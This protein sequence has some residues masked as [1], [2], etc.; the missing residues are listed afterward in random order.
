MNKVFVVIISI[1]IGGCQPSQ[2][3][4]E[5]IE[6]YGRFSDLEQLFRQYENQTLVINFWATSCGPCI[7]EMPH[8]NEL[9]AEQNDN[10]KIVLVSLDEPKYLD[11]RVYPFVK[12]HQLKPEAVLLG[13]QNYSAWT[14]K[15]DP[16]WRGALPATLIV[17]D[18]ERTFRF[19]AYES[20]E[21]LKVDIQKV[22]N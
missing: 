17:K 10:V 6:V 2:E 20:I 9:E 22:S 19:G 16:D 18:D 1:I 13:D 5:T 14:E 15:I 11:N 21:E 4:N 12:K 8:F 3:Y 7:K